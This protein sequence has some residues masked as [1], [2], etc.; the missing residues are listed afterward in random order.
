MRNLCV[1]GSVN[2]SGS[3]G[4]IAGINGGLVENCL[5]KAD[6]S[7]SITAGGIVGYNETYGTVSSCVNTGNV[8]GSVDAGGI[9]GCNYGMLVNSG[10][11]GDVSG[12]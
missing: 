3:T 12:S 10:N 1:E 2:G 6:V 11:T 7:S 8:S 9:V 4:A 5:G